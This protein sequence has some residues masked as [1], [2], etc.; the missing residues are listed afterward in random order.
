[1]NREYVRTGPVQHRQR[2]EHDHRDRQ[3]QSGGRIATQA[4][5]SVDQKEQRRDQRDAQTE[6]DDEIV[7]GGY[8]VST[9]AGT[10]PSGVIPSGLQTQL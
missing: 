3:H 8:L 4:G 6:T 2:D 10:G 9:S 1:M 7:H 5:E